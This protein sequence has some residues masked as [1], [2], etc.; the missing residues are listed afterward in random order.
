MN[1]I[2]KSLL[3]LM[4][5]SVVALLSSSK[6]QH[7]YSAKIISLGKSDLEADVWE[8]VTI[9]VQNTD[10]PVTLRVEAVKM[11]EEWEIKP[12]FLQKRMETKTS[13]DFTFHIKVPTMTKPADIYWAVTAVYGGFLGL[14]QKEQR[15][16]TQ[17]QTINAPKIAIEPENFDFGKVYKEKVSH[18]F[19]VKN[20]G[21]TDLKI[22]S[23]RTSCGCTTAALKS[24]D[25]KPINLNEKKKVSNETGYK[26]APNE[27]ATLTVT[28]DPLH[29]TPMRHSKDH[30][31][32]MAWHAPPSQNKLTRIVYIKSNDP[33]TP[34]AEIVVTIDQR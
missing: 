20:V 10:D 8:E 31:A 29:H 34:E 15:L 33:K 2:R 12:R 16:D 17:S 27:S 21:Y 5:F 28:Y 19:T 11:P 14:W 6:T 24:R 25:G 1:F 7:T 26:L 13:E 18:D 9:K 4:V 22:R 3:L 32:F 30:D 23:V